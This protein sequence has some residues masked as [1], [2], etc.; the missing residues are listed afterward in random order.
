MAK[1]SKGTY[2]CDGHGTSWLKIKSGNSQ[3]EGRHN[4]FEARRVALSDQGWGACSRARVDSSSFFNNSSTTFTPV[5]TV[6]VAAR[7]SL[8]RPLSVCTMFPC[9]GLHYVPVSRRSG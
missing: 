3:A 2:Q 9:H 1:W 8:T 7:I 5:P 6:E 4:L